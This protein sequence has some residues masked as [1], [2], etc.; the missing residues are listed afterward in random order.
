MPSNRARSYD[1]SEV[2][3]SF[4]SMLF[5]GDTGGG[6]GEGDFLTVEPESEDWKAKTGADGE[7][8]R[9]KTNNRNATL[10]LKTLQ[11]SRI[12]SMLSAARKR[13]LAAGSGAGVGELELRDRSSGTTLASTP[14][15]W[16][17]GMPNIVR[18]SEIGEVEW[19][20]FLAQAELDASAGE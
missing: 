20:I 13:D 17:V 1:A 14:T 11:T 2:S 18:G 19:K 15:A 3:L 6:F 7:V 12:N 10:T 8:A 5:T 16:I 9:A 4:L